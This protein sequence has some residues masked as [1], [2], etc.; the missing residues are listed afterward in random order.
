M[1]FRYLR[2]WKVNFFDWLWFLLVLRCDEFH[3]KLRLGT[4]KKDIYTLVK[5]KWKA[6]NI[7]NVLSVP[8][9]HVYL[10]DTKAL[11]IYLNGSY[12]RVEIDLFNKLILQFF[13]KRGLFNY[14]WSK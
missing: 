9:T 4:R 12:C 7:D 13:T 10:I 8:V 14:F 5:I 2:F 11:S 1:K 6:H 3:P